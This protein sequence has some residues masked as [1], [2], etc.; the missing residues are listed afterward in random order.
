MK[1]VMQYNTGTISEFI[2]RFPRADLI[3]TPTIIHK[4]PRLS[5]LLDHNVY[6]LREDLT[7]FALGGNK[8]RKVEYLFGDAVAKGADTLVTMKATSFSRNAAVAAS[9]LGLDLHVVLAG[10][11]PDQNPA[12]QTL[13]KQCGTRLYYTPGG[14]DALKVA[15]DQLAE[16]LMTSGKN[17]YELHPGGSDAIGALGYVRV[18]DELA[19]F[20]RHE[21]VHFS[22]I[23]H[24]TSSAGTQAG[25]VLGQCISGY[26]CRITGISAALEDQLQEE[27]IRE[28]VQSTADMLGFRLNGA[29]IDVDDR[30]I[31]PGYA[32]PSDQGADAV[33]LF[34]SLEGIL[35][36]QVY[37]GKAAGALIHFAKTSS[38]K[39]QNI[40]FI[41]TGGNA[42]LFY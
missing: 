36:D 24:S 18:F 16:R 27:K 6:I 21:K 1:N 3:K 17:V 15:H 13:F 8:T 34:A 7:G 4:L 9:A 10:T 5:S 11:E 22:H 32:I 26:D 29:K 40:L 31:G 28:L 30:F 41:H 37:A 12:S 14:A 39:G 19:G 23:I 35:L 38:L 20:S 33:R 42:G 25:L 2:D